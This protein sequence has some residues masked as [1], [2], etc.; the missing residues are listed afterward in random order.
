MVDYSFL[1]FRLGLA[2]KNERIGWQDKVGVI[3]KAVRV[4]EFWEICSHV[5][6]HMD[7]NGSPAWL[8]GKIT[9]EE[10]GAFD[11]YALEIGTRAYGGEN[12]LCIRIVL[13]PTKLG[14]VFKTSI[15]EFI[16]RKD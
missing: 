6:V 7:E 10:F 5:L 9:E 1:P 15:S 2:I 11:S 14:E 12:G 3:G 16:K 4:G 8:H 13:E